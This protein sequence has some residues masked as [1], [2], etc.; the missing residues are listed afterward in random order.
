MNSI[1]LH[2]QGPLTFTPGVR[3]LFHSP[4]QNAECVYLWTIQ[5]D[6]DNR[7]YI[8]YIGE[9]TS[10]A[11]RQREHLIQVL[12]LNYGIF[13]PAEAR[14][15]VQTRL[16]QGL[17][18]D[19]SPEGPGRLLEKYSQMTS[20]VLRYF[21]TLNVF[22][23]VTSVDRWTRKHIEGSIG[24]NLRNNHKSE[25]MLYPDDNRVGTM[26]A[27]VAHQLCISSDVP[28]AGLDSVLEV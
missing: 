9:A 1:A 22:A 4:L 28:I 2:F 5:S 6:V 27:K 15:G 16:S 24:W 13:D 18:R 11:R 3:S 23:A 7:F 12:G 19:R 14:N 8:H 20:D 10:F 21:E 26:A 25:K 17:W